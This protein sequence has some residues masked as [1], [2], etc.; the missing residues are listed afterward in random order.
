MT[1]RFRVGL[2]VR[3][4]GTEHAWRGI[5]TYVR[6]LRAALVGL[7]DPGLEIRE[8]GGR[9]D[10]RWARQVGFPLAAR[11]AEMEV[12]HVTAPEA[13]VWQPLP[14]VATVHDLAELQLG[15]HPRAVWRWRLVAMR[16][17]A[18][19]IVYSAATA[20]DVQ[21]WTAVSPERLRIIPNGVEPVFR[22]APLVPVH[23]RPYLLYVGGLNARKNLAGLLRAV[24]RAG[25]A[26]PD[27]ELIVV[28]RDRWSSCQTV[29][30]SCGLAGR[31]VV[32]GDAPASAALADL[33]RGAVAYLSASRY[34]GFG[35][36]VLE[37]MACGTP[38][39]AFAHSS[40]VEIVREGGILVP[41]G[42]EAAL[43]E[44]V[45]AVLADASRRAA[46]AAGALRDAARFSWER[47]A[48]QTR[49]VYHEAAGGAG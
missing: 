10:S 6:A 7:E 27:L 22:P 30:E 25:S 31:V 41:D 14:T 43:A 37:A 11:A 46:L 38:V 44:G 34:E 28:T 48:R 17:A 32:R 3:P 35:F 8:L 15:Q 19:I 39:V 9:L 29:V 33:Y 40:H 47:A 16:R 45:R 5:G 42:D 2:D 18:R 20:R 24:A 12:L 4:L 23:P 26:R 13:P 36:P 1:D 21:E 49:A